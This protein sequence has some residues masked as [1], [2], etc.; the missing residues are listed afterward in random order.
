MGVQLKDIKRLCFDEMWKID[1]VDIPCAGHYDI[2]VF[3]GADEVIKGSE[4][5]PLPPTRKQIETLMFISNLP[6]DFIKRESQLI[7]EHFRELVDTNTRIISKDINLFKIQDHCRVKE[8][9]IPYVKAAR[10]HNYIL[11]CVCDWDLNNGINLHCRDDK[12]IKVTK[13]ELGRS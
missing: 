6:H 1:A 5:A 11:C 7:R 2:N 10:K 12:I 8:V 4:W 13:A 3:F 9:I